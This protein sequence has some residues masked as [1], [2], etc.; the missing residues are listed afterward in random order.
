MGMHENLGVF[1]DAQAI[2]ANG[3]WSTGA[4]D[5]GVVKSQLGV[6]AYAPVLC[7]RTAVAPTQAGDT[8][9]IELRTSATLNIDSPTAPYLSGTI[10]NM[11][12]ICATA[13]AELSAAE[14]RFATAGA[15]IIRIPLPYDLLRYIQLYFLNGTSVG[16]FTIDGWLEDGAPSD[17]R[18]SQVL[19]SPVGNP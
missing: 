2:S 18:G 6:G 16:V 8:L 3:T 7:I 10:K 5:T 9:A 4:I 11:F 14:A 15:W 17:F 13:L 12:T 1:C 19:T